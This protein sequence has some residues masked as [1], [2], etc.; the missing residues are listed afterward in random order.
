MVIFYSYV[1][2]PEGGVLGSEV[3]FGLIK[4]VMKR[5]PDLKLVVMPLGLDGDGVSWGSLQPPSPSQGPRGGGWNGGESLEEEEVVVW[6]WRRQFF[7]ELFL[8]M[9]C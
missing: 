9:T 7:F 1:K 4:E 6:S 8:L 2:L 3:L 5:R